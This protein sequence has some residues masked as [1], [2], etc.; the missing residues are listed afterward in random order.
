[1]WGRGRGG[2]GEGKGCVGKGGVLWGRR[3]VGGGVLWGISPSYH[4]LC[5]IQAALSSH[6]PA[7]R[8]M[9]FM[10]RFLVLSSILT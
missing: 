6:W 3:S 5:F 7:H 9:V 10:A 1:V 2:V 4:L 8:A